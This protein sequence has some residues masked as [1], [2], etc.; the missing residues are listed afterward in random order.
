MAV[1]VGAGVVS[2]AQSASPAMACACGAPAPVADDPNGD[3]MINQEFAIIS[4]QSTSEQVDMRLSID[5][6]ARDSGLIMPTPSPADVSLGDASAFEALALEMTPTEVKSYNWWGDSVL[7]TGGSGAANNGA[8]G[9]AAPV[10]LDVVQLGPIE[11]TVLAASDTQGL[12]DWLDAN[13]YGIRPEVTDLL[14][15]YVDKNWSFVAMKLTSTDTLGGDLDP[16]RFVFDMPKSGLVYPLALSQ[17]ARSAQTVNVYIFDDHKRDVQFAN[18]EDLDL[19]FT[20]SGLTWAAP[21]SDPSLQAYGHYLSAYKLNFDQPDQ[22]ILDDLVFP[23]S[24][25]DTE[26]GTVVYTTVYVTFLGIPLGWFAVIVVVVAALVV[27]IVYRR[28]ALAGR[29]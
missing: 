4:S 13:G 24:F 18:G 26:Y 19:F 17:A 6:L 25:D 14:A 27:A 8:P 29:A 3:V 28:R 16:I 11:A 12:T 2:V 22:Q 5:S 7:E 1:V 15:T 10:V 20:S 21:V 23:Q 9:A